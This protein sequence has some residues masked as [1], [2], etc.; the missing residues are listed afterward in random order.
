MSPGPLLALGVASCLATGLAQAEATPQ[1]QQAPETP[2]RQQALV[3]PLRQQ[4]LVT[5]Q[6]QQALVHMV[7]QDCGACHGLQLTGGLGPPLTPQALSDRSIE[8]IVATTLHGR[9]GTP[10]PPWKSMLSEADALWI[11]Q[12]LRAGFPDETKVAK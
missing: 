8:A 4:A 11:A 2:Q 9:P 3:T 5:P 1:R 12:Q 10:M 7:R 6:R